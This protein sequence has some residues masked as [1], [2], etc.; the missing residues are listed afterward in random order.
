MPNIHTD[1][2]IL[3]IFKDDIVYV[4]SFIMYH[5]PLVR[6]V[7]MLDTGSTD[8]SYEAALAAAG[9]H[10]NV[11]VLKHEFKE[12]DFSA[13]RNKCLELFR[14]VR[15]PEITHVVWVDTDEQLK[16]TLPDLPSTKAGRLLRHDTSGKF[17]T[18]LDRVFEVDLPG[19]WV[20]TIH[21]GYHADV[22]T[23]THSVDGMT[24][25]HLRSEM[26]RTPQKK[27]QYFSLL[28]REL[29]RDHCDN[30]FA[31]QYAAHAIVMASYDLEDPVMAVELYRQ[32]ENLFLREGQEPSVTEV[33][34]LIHVVRC[35]SE[36][37]GDA[38]DLALKVI[39][40]N[41]AKPTVYQVI[42]GLLLNPQNTYR[43]EHYYLEVYPDLPEEGRPDLWN[44]DYC[45]P[46][47][48][49]LFERRIVRQKNLLLAGFDNT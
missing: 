16:V 12:V 27:H 44:G 31:Q 23:A 30:I 21:E 11:T 9:L 14:Q 19:R 22:A 1:A 3:N 43:V 15:L 13:F 45:D 8:G 26:A 49:E 17:H 2:A 20:G 42:R 7:V 4:V 34:A 35:R 46:R 39:A 25:W 40:L 37:G 5:A 33:N 32:Y 18:W 10:S 29:E 24:L 38:W 41:R 6:Q 48:V 36:L 47:Q 28:L